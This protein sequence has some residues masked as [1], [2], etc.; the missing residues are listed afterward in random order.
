[1]KLGIFWGGAV[2][3]SVGALVY[4]AGAGM[5]LLL[6]ALFFNAVLVLIAW[7]HREERRAIMIVAAAIATVIVATMVATLFV[8]NPANGIMTILVMV[9]VAD[10]AIVW[11]WRWTNI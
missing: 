11:R 2:I 4:K 8:G 6:A 3:A 7:R 1:M 5:W 10:T 9:I